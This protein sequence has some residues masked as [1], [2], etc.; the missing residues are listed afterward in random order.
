MFALKHNIFC[1]KN[2]N[3]QTCGLQAGYYR[4]RQLGP[5]TMN[6]LGMT[7]PD[8]PAFDQVLDLVCSMLQPDAVLRPTAW[9]LLQHPFLA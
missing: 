1:L 8:Q 9:E 4:A 7:F 6:T 2:F 3:A 5:D